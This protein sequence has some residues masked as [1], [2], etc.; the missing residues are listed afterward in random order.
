[1][2][3][4]VPK[5]VLGLLAKQP[6][7][8]FVKTRLAAQTSPEWAARVAEAFLTDS[9]N[10]LAEIEARRVL[11]YTPAEARSFFSDLVQGRFIL[12]PQVE[13]DLGRRMAAFFEGVCQQAPVRAILLGVDSPTLPLPYIQDAFDKL[14]GVDLVLGPATDGGF[15]LVGWSGHVPPIFDNINW[16]Q[17]T[18]LGD[19]IARLHASCRLALLAPWYDVDTLND[20]QMLQGH[21]AALKRAG[22][23]SNLPC[24]EKLALES[25]CE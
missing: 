13:G 18:V 14:D 24:T 6:L 15:Y 22:L 7:P 8:G 4:P 16:S 25:V 1:M 12:Q 23:D 10:R 20:W 5:R 11:A 17:P 19:T 3:E 2:G 9:V 21:L